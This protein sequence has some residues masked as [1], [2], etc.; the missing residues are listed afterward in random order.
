MAAKSR[1]SLP[2]GVRPRTYQLW[3]LCS[4]YYGKKNQ[5]GLRPLK[6][7]LSLAEGLS[8]PDGVTQVV[9]LLCFS[10]PGRWNTGFG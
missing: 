9:V 8:R 3:S 10:A 2:F 7:L 5:M 4:G 1:C 6:H